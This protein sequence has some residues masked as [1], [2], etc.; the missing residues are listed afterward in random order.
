[1]PAAHAAPRSAAAWD[2]AALP[3]VPSSIASQALGGSRRRLLDPATK[4]SF[5]LEAARNNDNRH[6]AKTFNLTVRQAHAIRVSLSRRIEEIRSHGVVGNG[7]APQAAGAPKRAAERRAA[8]APTAADLQAQR[9]VELALQE[10]FLKARPPATPTVDDVVRYLRQIGDVVV[11]ADEGAYRVNDRLKLSE[12]ELVERANRKR[13]DRHQPAF[14]IPGL[15]AASES[16]AEPALAAA[17]S[18]GSQPH[19][20]SA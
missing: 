10:E 17:A 13:L 4:E 2:V 14:D 15:T 1:V 7:H 18:N 8:Q 9:A 5:A 3:S 20:V 6:L 11:R 16:Q 12:P 19:L